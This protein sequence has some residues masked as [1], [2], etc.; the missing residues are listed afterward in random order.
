[1]EAITCTVTSLPVPVHLHDTACRVP[2]VTLLN[3]YE[4]IPVT[5]RGQTPKA[6]T[7]QNILNS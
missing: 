6:N 4:N 7:V 5:M 3:S 1:M 2:N